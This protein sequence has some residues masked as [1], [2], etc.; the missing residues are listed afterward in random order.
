MAHLRRG[1][2]VI[3]TVLAIAACE[4]T[5]IEPEPEYP[6]ITGSWMGTGATG[7]NFFDL[8]LQLTQEVSGRVTG[9][10]RLQH[11]VPN[12]PSFNFTVRWGAY[13]YP[14][15]LVALYAGPNLVD[16]SYGGRF[17]DP[18]KIEGLMN[19]SGFNNV[20]VTLTRR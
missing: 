20:P 6:S 11:V 1:I 14:D 15:L 19:G 5:P 10:G 17:A 3:L 13:G 2:G 9:T 18:N 16:V 12:Q 7:V 4:D 8:S